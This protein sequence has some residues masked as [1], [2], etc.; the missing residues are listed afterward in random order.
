MSIKDIKE[1]NTRFL[2][3]IEILKAKIAELKKGDLHERVLFGLGVYNGKI[4]DVMLSSARIDPNDP[5]M[6]VVFTAHDITQ[7]KIT[8]EKYTQGFLMSPD[9]I[10][11]IR[12]S[13]GRFESVSNSFTSI[14]EY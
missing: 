4:L 7:R 14:L 6:N 12:L 1:L 13:D 8:E 9:G 5:T 10:C 2:K 11:V 3:E